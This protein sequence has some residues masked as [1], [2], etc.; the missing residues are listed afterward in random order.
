MLKVKRHVKLGFS[1]L[2]YH[3]RGTAER[4]SKRT[5][6]RARTPRRT[7]RP[8]QHGS[9]SPRARTPARGGDRPAAAG[10]TPGAH[11]QESRRSLDPHTNTRPMLR[12]RKARAPGKNRLRFHTHRRTSC[13]VMY[14][15]RRGRGWQMVGEGG[16]MR[17]TG[18]CIQ[19]ALHLPRRTRM[20]APSYH[21]IKLGEPSPASACARKRSGPTG[22]PVCNIGAHGA[23]GEGANGGEG[24]EPGERRRSGWE[25]WPESARA[26]WGGCSV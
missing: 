18:S 25:V 5:C 4:A 21:L 17:D 22:M 14:A 15:T 7:H 2:E 3:R 9:Q 26:G 1:S 16:R 10:K 11:I 12:A 23:A 8:R 24:N 19:A 20:S 6:I 13:Q